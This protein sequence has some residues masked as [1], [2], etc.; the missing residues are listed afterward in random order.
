LAKPITKR[1]HSKDRFIGDTFSERAYKPYAL[2]IGQFVL[3]WNAFHEKLGM[4]FVMIL[5][6]APGWDIDRNHDV[7]GELF[8]NDDAHIER[9]SGVWSSAPLDRP[10]RAM[11]RGLLNSFIEADL[12][13]FPKFIGDLSWILDQADKI[14]DIRNN[15]VHTPLLWIGGHPALE[16]IVAEHD[17]AIIPNVLLANK[18]AVAVAK[19]DLRSRLVIEYR[20]GRDASVILRDFSGRIG[21]AMSIEGAPWPQRPSLPNRGQRVGRISEA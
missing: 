21:H 18:R 2:A 3:A 19:K 12:K 7:D 5:H 8:P 20:W 11:L 14:E 10:K 6:S 4:L 17:V 9:W 13:Q 1:R 16:Q 15:A